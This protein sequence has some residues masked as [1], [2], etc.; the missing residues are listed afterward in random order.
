LLLQTH[1]LTNTSK[2]MVSLHPN[3]VTVVAQHPIE[4][5]EAN[6]W[7]HS[8]NGMEYRVVRNRDE[9]R[10][11]LYEN[12][13]PERLVTT[14]VNNM[15]G[16][17]QPCGTFIRHGDLS[18]W[19]TSNVINMSCMFYDA[20]FFNGD[21]S[22]WDTSNVTDMS[23][24]F[25]NAR[26]FNGDLSAWNT[27]NVTDTSQMFLF[28]RAFNGDLSAW[29]ISNVLDMHG[30]FKGAFLFNGDLSAWDTSNV[31][32]MMFMFTH[33]HAFN[34]DLSAWNTSNVT[35]TRCMF[36]KAKS[37]N[38]DVSA[39]DTSNVTNQKNM[40]KG[41]AIRRSIPWCPDSKIVADQNAWKARR[42]KLARWRWALECHRDA[43][44]CESAAKFGR[45]MELAKRLRRGVY[46]GG[47]AF[48]QKGASNSHRDEVDQDVLAVIATFTIT[49]T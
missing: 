3:D 2:I 35:D 26:S 27:S 16:L 19:D 4:W 38:G 47:L 22:A 39:W 42:G 40:F 24:M 8:L 5:Y 15:R 10:E 33:A 9:L 34:G 23:C 21:L 11:Q 25:Y 14:F 32:N 45:P 36:Y 17:L 41:S 6:G 28:A 44:H 30:M 1:Q 20:T 46:A 49:D 29:D 48:A 37:F 12:A 43:S 18:A 31:T 13:A 7:E